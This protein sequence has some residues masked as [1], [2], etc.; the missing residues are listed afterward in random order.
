MQ[1]SGPATRLQPVIQCNVDL[2]RCLLVG[3]VGRA[4]IASS[5]TDKMLLFTS[6]AY[7]WPVALKTVTR[8]PS[9]LQ[10]NFALLKA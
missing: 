8:S 5:V 10:E 2:C 4:A 1:G 7:H 3:A 9:H 6:R